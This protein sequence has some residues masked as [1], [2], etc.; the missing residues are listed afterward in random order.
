VG[1]DG[2][3]RWQLALDDLA[4]ERKLKAAHRY[5]DE[6]TLEVETAIR[7]Q[8]DRFGESAHRCELIREAP[9]FESGL[10]SPEVTP[11]YESFG[12]LRVS[13]GV[14]DHVISWQDHIRP[15]CQQFF[16]WAERA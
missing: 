6:R 10:R 13:E 16:A 2:L 8:I 15:L 4:F 12:R 5:Y 1:V 11:Y 9:P 3:R 14:Y 7:E